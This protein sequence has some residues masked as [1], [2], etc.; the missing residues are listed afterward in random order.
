[1]SSVSVR[2]WEDAVRREGLQPPVRVRPGLFTWLRYAAW[3]PIPKRHQG[4]VLYDTTCSTWGQRHLVRILA[5]VAVP[6]A[7]LA[8]F[9]P[10]SPA[11][12]AL[13]CVTTGLCAVFFPSL[14]INEATDHRLYQAGLPASLGPRIR[15]TR[16]TNGQAFANAARRERAAARR[17]R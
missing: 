17:S 15:Q 9:L 8:L 4:W 12:R 13:T 3:F 16:A 14:Y 1:M 7:A 10:A 5:L 6:T 2:A 11:I